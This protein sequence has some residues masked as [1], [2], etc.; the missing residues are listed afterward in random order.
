MHLLSGNQTSPRIALVVGFAVWLTAQDYSWP[1][2]HRLIRVQSDSLCPTFPHEIREAV[3]PGHRPPQRCHRFIIRHQ[4]YLHASQTRR[5]DPLV[6]W[7]VMAA[8]PPSSARFYRCCA[9]SS[10]FLIKCCRADGA[11]L[12]QVILGCGL[13]G[14][15]EYSFQA[16]LLSV[17]ISFTRNNEK[18]FWHIICSRFNGNRF[19]YG[20]FPSPG[21]TCPSSSYLKDFSFFIVFFFFWGGGG[22][23]L[24]TLGGFNHPYWINR[25]FSQYWLTA[26][27][28]SIY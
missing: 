11:H 8:F 23:E 14:G 19:I 12:I 25:S 10:K 9:S 15:G 1:G 6:P 17:R 4:I 20:F 7:S 16:Q 21:A 28:T 26:R 5:S 24:V 13:E 3:P 27:K 22:G 18:R 2:N